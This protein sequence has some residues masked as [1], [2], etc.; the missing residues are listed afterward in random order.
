MLRLEKYDIRLSTLS[1]MTSYLSNRSQYVSLN[2]VNFKYKAVE[3]DVPQGSAIR[4]LLFLIYASQNCMFS[5]PILF[6]D[7]TA[8][9]VNADTLQ[10]LE[11]LLNFE[12][13][14]IIL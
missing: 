10:K 1:L 7:D 12:L 2:N 11:F 3:M 13:S 5:L 4:P 8:V 14:K 6:A 9:V